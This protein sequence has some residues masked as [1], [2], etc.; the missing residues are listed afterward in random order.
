V[1][2]P[3]LVLVGA[4]GAGKTTVGR[5]VA[6]R[7]SLAFRDT[8][9]D[10]ERAAGELVATIFV[11]QGE[12]AFRALERAAVRR[13]LDEHDGVLALGSG[14]VL[15]AATR[16]RLR[17]HRVVFLDVGLAAAAKRVGLARDRPAGLGNPRAQLHRLLEARRPLYEEV[18]TTTVRTDERTPDEVAATV[19]GGYS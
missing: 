9:A 7:L 15:D 17:A 11:E 12:E 6:E 2:G 10:V 14:A 19:V 13:A 4:P 18:A 1:T 3:R 16:A 8:D 5:L